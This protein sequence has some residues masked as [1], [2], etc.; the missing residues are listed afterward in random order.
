MIFLA[1]RQDDRL[2]YENGRRQTTKMGNFKGMVSDRF[3]AQSSTGTL[4]FGI[5]RSPR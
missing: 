4:A 1:Q 3:V 5:R 2:R